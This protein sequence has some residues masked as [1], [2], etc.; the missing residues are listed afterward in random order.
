[1]K[2]KYCTFFDKNFISRASALIYSIRKYDSKNEILILAIDDE[3]KHHFK[4]NKKIEVI[5]LSVLGINKFDKTSKAFYFRLTPL[6]CKYVIGS[7]K[8][9]T[10]I[11][12]LDADLYFFNSPKKLFDEVRDYSI[13]F[14]EQF[15]P[16]WR[17]P[18]IK[19]TGRFS[20]AVNFF[21]NDIEGNKCI[22]YWI[23][24]SNT[25][26]KNN[27]D[28]IQKF[29]DQIFLDDWPKKFNSLKIIENQGVNVAPW[30]IH[31]Y[32]ISLKNNEFYVNKTKLI[33]YHFSGLYQLSENLW[34]NNMSENFIFY[35]K[36]IDKI[37]KIYIN[38]IYKFSNNK[39][40]SIFKYPSSFISPLKKV[41]KMFS[42]DLIKV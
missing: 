9:N 33:I 12:Y 28:S 21:K 36:D 11:L 15:L 20:V 1:M 40:V 37:Y 6:L 32:E 22:N 38:H 4:K 27:L 41:I 5:D 35:K 30:N 25:W 10:H 24:Q 16:L 34:D 42:N 2:I 3:V 19:Y 7:V 23:E 17:K 29:S 39:P 18:R 13:A 31:R 14:S 26:L 8:K